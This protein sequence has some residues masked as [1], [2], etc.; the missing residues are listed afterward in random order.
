[1]IFMSAVG[2]LLTF[3][4]ASVVSAQALDDAAIAAMSAEE[5]IATGASA[6][7]QIAESSARIIALKEEAVATEEDATRVR[8]LNE[9]SV[10][11]N[12]F[13]AVATQSYEQLQTSVSAGDTRAANHHLLMITVSAQRSK[14]IEAQAAQCMGGELRFVGDSQTNQQI[15]PRL[16]EYDPS[17]FRDDSGGAFI[18]VEELPP[19]ASAER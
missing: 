2:A 14:G 12:G 6:R 4:G 5:K 3:G 17:A 19:K 8:C 9:A 15:D 7:R 16:A 10:T 11:A 13:L 1:M 18:F